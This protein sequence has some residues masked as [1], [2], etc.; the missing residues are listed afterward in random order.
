M[1]KG[2]KPVERR[3]HKRFRVKPGA[4]AVLTPRWPHSTP[5]GDILD[6]STGGL[7]LRYVTDE[8]P[9]SKP[10]ELTIVCVNPGFYLGRVSVN[11]VSDFEMARTTFASMVPRRLGFQFGDLTADQKLDLDYFI[12]T[13]TT[14][15]V[16]AQNV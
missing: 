13:Y 10:C 7:A 16:E 3:K 2:K 14:P 1:A 6:I 8:V 5:V 11:A 4:V 15:E 12:Q 9:S